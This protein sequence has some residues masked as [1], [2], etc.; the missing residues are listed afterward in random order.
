MKLQQTN[1]YT[2]FIRNEEQRVINA[3]H[4]KKIT[5]SI[6]RLG[7]LPSKPIQVFKN[8]DGKLVVV[9]GHHR[10]SAAIE[11]GATVYYVVE[12]ADAQESMTVENLLVRKWSLMEFVRLYAA[13]GDKNYATLLRYH[14]KGFPVATAAA[15]LSNHT[16]VGNIRNIHEGTFKVR[17]TKAIDTIADFISEFS[18]TVP[19]VKKSTFISALAK[20]LFVSEFDIATFRHRLR[21]NPELMKGSSTVDGTI[22]EFESVY[23]Y[24]LRS[25]IPL[26]HLVSIAMRNRNP[27]A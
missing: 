9:D 17:E 5:E 6:K 3:G 14:D 22:S 11:L 27:V 2:L 16:S 18:N 13:R 25:P 19:A 26:R 1:N 4:V 23:N 24:R 10:L 7:F 20:C 15:L 12:G 21:E 8:K